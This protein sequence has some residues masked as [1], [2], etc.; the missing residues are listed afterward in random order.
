[1]SFGVIVSITTQKLCWWDRKHEGKGPDNCLPTD[2]P[3]DNKI[4]DGG[5]KYVT[6]IKLRNLFVL[7]VYHLL[8][9]D[10]IV[11]VFWYWT[12]KRNSG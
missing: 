8:V 10:T 7:Q 11:N 5:S 2:S 4:K 12:Q 9:G 6:K 1:M 3:R